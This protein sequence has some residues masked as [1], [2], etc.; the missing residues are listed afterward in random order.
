LCDFKNEYFLITTGIEYRNQM[1]WLQRN[2]AKRHTLRGSFVSLHF[3][4][5][6]LAPF[7]AASFLKRLHPR[8]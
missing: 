4:N 8:L 7:G 3:A 5:S 6:G 2:A 1:L